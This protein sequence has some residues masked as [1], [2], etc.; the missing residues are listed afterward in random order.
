M[1]NSIATVSSMHNIDKSFENAWC[2]STIL[3]EIY[4]CFG[5]SVEYIIFCP[6]NLHPAAT[7]FSGLAHYHY[8][9]I[10]ILAIFYGLHNEFSLCSNRLKKFS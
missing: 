1:D 5:K 6:D 2:C 7:Q 8:R 3:N 4:Q 10:L 9:Q